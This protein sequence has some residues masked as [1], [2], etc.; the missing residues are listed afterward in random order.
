MITALLL[1]GVVCISAPALQADVCFENKSP[2]PREV[3]YINQNGVEVSVGEIPAGR[4]KCVNT[5]DTVVGIR[6]SGSFYVP[7][8]PSGLC[9][10]MP[11]ACTDEVC[12]LSN[13]NTFT[14]R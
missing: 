14:I 13:D 9:T 3:W 8:P 1:V 4:K 2:C 6:V 7:A 10:A 11:T 5:D 12:R